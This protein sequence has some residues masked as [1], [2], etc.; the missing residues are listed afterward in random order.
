[1]SKP[2]AHNNSGRDLLDCLVRVDVLR[3]IVAYNVDECPPVQ[4]SPDGPRFQA[5]GAALF[6]TFHG[7]HL[8]LAVV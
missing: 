3:N 6:F 7:I 1:M 4:I 5:P 8:L 2:S